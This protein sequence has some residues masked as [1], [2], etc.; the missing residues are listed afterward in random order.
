MLIPAPFTTV[1]IVYGQAV[2]ADEDLQFGLDLVRR[3]ALCSG[4]HA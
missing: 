4:S 3:R 2:A 1:E